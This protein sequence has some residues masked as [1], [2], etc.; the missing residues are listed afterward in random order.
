M[1]N[2]KT[3]IKEPIVNFFD[4]LNAELKDFDAIFQRDVVGVGNSAHVIIP[5]KYI[6]MKARIIIHN[7]GGSHIEIINHKSEVEDKKD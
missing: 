6:G 1:E 4:E 7:R 2:I 5:K 3:D